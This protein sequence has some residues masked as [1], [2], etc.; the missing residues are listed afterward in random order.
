MIAMV[1]LFVLGGVQAADARLAATLDKLDAASARF[2][3][4]RRMCGG[5]PTL[6]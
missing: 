1:M 4:P 2:V 3:S 6:P 5:R